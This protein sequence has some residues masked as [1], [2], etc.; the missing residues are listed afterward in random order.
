MYEIHETYYYLYVYCLWSSALHLINNTNAMLNMLYNDQLLSVHKICSDFLIAGVA[1]II[2]KF[3]RTNRL[4]A[5]GLRPSYKVL[6]IFWQLADHNWFSSVCYTLLRYRAYIA[7]GIPEILYHVVW[8]INIPL[9]DN[10]SY[11]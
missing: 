7:F 4:W 6:F 9:Y 8:Y 2:D 5:P 10:I 1:K 11:L 3:G